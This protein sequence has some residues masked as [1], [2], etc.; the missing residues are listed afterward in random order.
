MDRLE[1]LCQR[2]T[3]SFTARQEPDRSLDRHPQRRWTDRVQTP[4]GPGSLDPWDLPG[5][6]VTLPI[7]PTEPNTGIQYGHVAGSGHFL[8]EVRI[9]S[10]GYGTLPFPVPGQRG[11]GAKWKNTKWKYINGK[12]DC[13]ARPAWG[14]SPVLKD[15]GL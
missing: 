13:K 2:E 5:A 3:F 7:F 6:M 11:P 9:S 1:Q 15:P 4:R 8:A 10:R 12:R 14:E